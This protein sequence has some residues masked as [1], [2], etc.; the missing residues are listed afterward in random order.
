MVNMVKRPLIFGNASR[1]ARGMDLL[2]FWQLGISPIETQDNSLVRSKVPFLALLLG[3][4]GRRFVLLPASPFDFPQK[5]RRHHHWY[6]VLQ[7]PVQSM[8][9]EMTQIADYGDVGAGVT[10][11][12]SSDYQSPKYE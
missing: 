2:E 10:I 6:Q 11:G 3:L 7:W 5:K 4:P 8:Q 9:S 12:N 1:P